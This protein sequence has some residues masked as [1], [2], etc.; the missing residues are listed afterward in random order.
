M[1][2]LDMVYIKNTRTDQRSYPSPRKCLHLANKKEGQ[3]SWCVTINCIPII[4]LVFL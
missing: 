2:F 3:Y 1:F 4:V